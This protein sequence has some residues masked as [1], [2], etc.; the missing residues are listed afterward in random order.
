MRRGKSRA[1]DSSKVT[2]HHA[3]IPTK[4]VTA[5]DSLSKEEQQI[6]YLLA[7]AYAAQFMPP[8]RWERTVTTLKIEGH[9]FVRTA[10]VTI[11]NG[12]RNLYADEP[13]PDDTDTDDG[14]DE[15]SI[16][17]VFTSGMEIACI[18]GESTRE[19]T[20]PKPL[21]TMSS[22]L[23]DLTRV[24]QYV[25]DEKLRKILVEKDKDKPGERGGIGTPA[26]RD[27]IIKTL[28]QRGFIEYS[29]KGK[30][31][32]VVSTKTGREFYDCLPDNAKFPDMTALWHDQQLEIEN[33]SRSIDTFVDDLLVYLGTEIA[34]VL[35]HGLGLNIE[36]HPCPECGNAMIPKKAGSKA[37]W[38][39]S[40][41][42]NCTVTLPDDKGKPGPRSQILAVIDPSVTCPLC[43]KPMRLRSHAKGDFFGCSDYPACKGSIKAKDGKP[44]IGEPRPSVSEK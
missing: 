32:I 15:V 6:Y 20:A 36:K 41:Y 5:S 22:L 7:R 24:A 28:F 26:T 17:P 43:G 10:K 16:T 4:A 21:Y 12:W 11:E 30:K 25:S 31:Q 39:C 34:R 37:F 9:T 3:I 1:F 19:E 13:K 44:V 40:N 42:P 14:D 27:E 23:E 33:G 8:Y 2:A 38:G 35:D 18:S 29:Q